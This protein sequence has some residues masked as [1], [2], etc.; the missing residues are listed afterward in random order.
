M[1]FVSFI[2]LCKLC[3]FSWIIF[4]YT[5]EAALSTHPYSSSITKEEREPLPGP[6]FFFFNSWRSL[7]GWWDVICL[8]EYDEKEHCEYTS[9]SHQEPQVET[10]A[11]CAGKGLPSREKRQVLPV[12]CYQMLHHSTVAAS[13]SW[14]FSFISLSFLS[15]VVLLKLGGEAAWTMAWTLGK[16]LLT[17]LHDSVSDSFHS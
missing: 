10:V 6:F 15:V 1:I 14:S 3:L 13:L 7:F 8:S 9:R 5:T 17:I 2:F 11:L 12:W 16:S 4:L